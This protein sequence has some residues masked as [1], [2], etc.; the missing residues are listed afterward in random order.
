MSLGAPSGPVQVHV[1][2]QVRFDDGVVLTDRTV[3][4]PEEI[5]RLQPG[6]DVMAVRDTARDPAAAPPG[7]CRIVD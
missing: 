5:V 7:T 3:R 4:I 1:T 2:V 6:T